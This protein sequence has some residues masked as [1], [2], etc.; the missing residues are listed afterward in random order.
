MADPQV[1]LAVAHASQQARLAAAIAAIVDR[2]YRQQVTGLSDPVIEAWIAA[3]LP[4]I[5][6][7]RSRSA[8]QAAA[9]YRRSRILSGEPTST[10][11]DLAPLP[12]E[13]EAVTTSLRVTGMSHAIQALERG[14]TFDQALKVGR[15]AAQGA[16][17]RHSL[18][19]GRTVLGRAWVNDPVRLGAYRITQPGCCSF[20]AM[21]ASRG[22]VYSDQ[23]FDASDPRFEGD[24]SDVKV[25]DH[26]RCTLGF[27]YRDGAAPEF[28]DRMASLW[29][30]VTRDENDRIVL[31]GKAAE[32]AF[33]R[34]YE[35]TLTV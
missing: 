34:V 3:V 15:T 19:G 23:S 17:M 2:S 30:Q 20:C 12:V 7:Y 35:A 6:E 13:M 26:D 25:H 10:I 11:P 9:Y 5:E 33:R 8:G 4:R 28:N 31:H 1:R 27:V 14:E 21:L 32:R 29:Q 22:A 16:A 24:L 18:D